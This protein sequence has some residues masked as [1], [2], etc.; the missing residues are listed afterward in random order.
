VTDVPSGACTK[1]RLVHPYACLADE[2][3]RI[4]A[5][6]PSRDRRRVGAVRAALAKHADEAAPIALAKDSA[7]A[8]G[9]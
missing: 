6:G 4:E 3:V 5:A 1:G 9:A 8:K 2:L 7:L